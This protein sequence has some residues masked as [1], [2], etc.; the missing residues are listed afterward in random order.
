MR[1]I[2]NQVAD[3]VELAVLLDYAVAIDEI[4]IGKLRDQVDPAVEDRDVLEVL[5]F[6]GFL[7]DLAPLL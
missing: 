7:V 5:G 2:D 4:L 6:G 1:V 3:G